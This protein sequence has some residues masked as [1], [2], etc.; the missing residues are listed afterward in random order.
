MRMYNFCSVPL[1]MILQKCSMDLLIK[2][3]T[4][5]VTLLKC[6]FSLTVARDKLKQWQAKKKSP[7]EG[8][9]KAPIPA[10]PIVRGIRYM[11]KE[12]FGAELITTHCFA[13]ERN[14]KL[15]GLQPVRRAEMEAI[16]GIRR[17]NYKLIFNSYSSLIFFRI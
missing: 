16:T 12:H 7:K 8:K 11:A 14:S 2:L 9:R 13:G 3:S 4:C 17:A 6:I 15:P 5:N 1:Y 10:N